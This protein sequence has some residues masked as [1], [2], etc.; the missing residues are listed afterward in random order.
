MTEHRTALLRTLAT[1][2]VAAIIG[3]V[4][5]LTA[6][7]HAFPQAAP[8][9]AYSVGTLGGN[10][11][12]QGSVMVQTS[13]GRSICLGAGLNGQVLKSGGAGADVGWL[14]VT[15]T[16]TVTSVGAT[17]PAFMAISGSPI[18]A[19][20]TLGFTFNTENQ[21]LVLAG[22]TTGAAAVPAFRALVGADIPA[23]NLA[24]SGN[25]GVT[26]QLPL[27]TGVSGTL[28]LTSQVAG[29]LPIANGGTNAATATGATTNIQS[30]NPATG[31]SARSV[32]SKLNDVV[33]VADFGAVCNGSTVDTTAIQ[34]A[35][36]SAAAGVVVQFPAGTCL[37]ATLTVP[38]G[39]SLRGQ[40]ETATN[41]QTNSA[42]ANAI[43]FNGAASSLSE[44]QLSASVARTAGAYV[45]SNN[46]VN[47]HDISV[48]GAFVGFNISGTSST[49]LA[50]DPQLRNINFFSPATGVGSAGAIFENYSNAV[51]VHS[52]FTGTASGQQPDYG[53]QFKNGD[54]AFVAD[55][56]VT[57]MGYALAIIPGS[58]ENNYSFNASNDDFDSGGLISGSINAN[59]CELVPTLTGNIYEAHFT[60]VWCGLSLADGVLM[61]TAGTGVLQGI[62]WSGGIFDGNGG[63]GFH[64]GSGVSYWSVTGG[65]AA[66]NTGSGYYVSGASSDFMLNGVQAGPVAGR[67]S[68]LAAA[69]NIGTATDADFYINANTNGNTGGGLVNAATTSSWF[70]IEN[71]VPSFPSFTHSQAENDTSVVVNVPLTGAT[72]TFA[73]T[74]ET[75]IINPAGTLANLT[76]K[77]GTC[78]AAANGTVERFS[79]TQTL[80]ATLITSTSGNVSNGFSTMAAGTGH[81]YICVGASST[82]F[83]LY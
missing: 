81:E 21:N 13:G 11:A 59:S 83:V 65:H 8:F 39:V 67:G 62:H 40:G 52:I 33:F 16:G 73:Q 58:G 37:Y 27:S 45:F 35:L 54:T 3:V 49:A 48:V 53:L 14:T 6:P 50:V 36:N 61:N 51:V 63:S 34:N 79:T 30:L 2:A 23:I 22:P 80:T 5:W 32:Q 10:C 28:S 76:I 56:N 18:T 31:G 41:L 19:A 77:L 70:T 20:G 68:N 74:V 72:V 66:G 64:V 47:I 17:V 57:R 38:A 26:G 7:E 43:T 29:V 78:N 25:G 9:N 60:N 24:G 69:V 46:G 42:T 71:G 12:A 44:L 1:F 15:G 82:W 75:E 4:A 55:T